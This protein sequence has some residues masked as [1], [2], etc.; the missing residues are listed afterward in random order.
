MSEFLNK[1]DE[2]VKRTGCSYE[3]AKNAL[4]KSDGDLLEALIYIEKHQSKEEKFKNKSEDLVEEIKK[5]VKDVNATRIIILKEDET[6]VNIPISAGAVGVIIAPLLSVL[7]LTA[8]MLTKYE[9]EIISKD[10]DKININKQL[11]K[12][13]NKIKDDFENIGKNK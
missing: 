12:S 8:A 7:G 6:L 1:A 10:G 3:E 2:L 9:I 11:E 13:L 5:I 4:Q